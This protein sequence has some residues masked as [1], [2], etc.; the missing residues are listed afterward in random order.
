MAKPTKHP[1]VQHTPEKILANGQF[2]HG[3]HHRGKTTFML[4]PTGSFGYLDVRPCG[5]ERKSGRRSDLT[6]QGPPADR[7]EGRNGRLRPCP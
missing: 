1:G 4:I 6:L 2:E 7:D 3:N 5:T